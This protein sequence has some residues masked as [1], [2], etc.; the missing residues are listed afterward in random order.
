MEEKLQVL[1][2]LNEK[3]L[4]QTYAYWTVVE[5]FRT[6]EYTMEMEIKLCHLRAFRDQ[7]KSEYIT[8]RRD[9]QGN[10]GYNEEQS[11]NNNGLN[12]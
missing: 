1:E 11:N 9:D 4:S 12:P 5:T 6:D 10:S 8:T 7:Q 3:I 2:T